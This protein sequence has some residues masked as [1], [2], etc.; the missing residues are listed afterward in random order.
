ME[1]RVTKKQ[2]IVVDGVKYKAKPVPPGT[3]RGCAFYGPEGRETCRR[4]GDKDVCDFHSRTDYQSVVWVKKEPKWIP[5]NGAKPA[6]LPDDALVLWK[7]TN[8][9]TSPKN[10]GAPAG[11]LNWGQMMGHRVTHYRLAKAP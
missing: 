10:R 6:D 8:G 3:C 5:V 11:S 4:V 2:N 9:C 1:I 7:A